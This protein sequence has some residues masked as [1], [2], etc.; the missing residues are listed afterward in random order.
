MKELLTTFH[1]DGMQP[2]STNYQHTDIVS[3]ADAMS[4]QNELSLSSKKDSSFANQI[5]DK[6]G[7]FS[8]DIGVRK[9]DFERKLMKASKSGES[10]DVLEAS[11]AMAEY[12]LQVS[13]ATKVASKTTSAIEKLTN[14]Q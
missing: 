4:F 11:R 14:L 9:E 1:S 8:K 5:I 13:I 2:L 6:F 10:A 12:Q 3:D 7:E